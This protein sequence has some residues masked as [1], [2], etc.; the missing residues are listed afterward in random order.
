MS[1]SDNKTDNITQPTGNPPVW[2]VV[3]VNL[4]LLLV[5]TSILLPLFHLAIGYVKWLLATGAL[6]HLAG[7]VGAFGCYRSLPVRIRRLHRMEL[8]AALFF[9]VAAVFMFIKVGRVTDCIAFI[10]AG[11]ATLLYTSLMIPRAQRDRK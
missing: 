9:V 11:G 2:S 8:W 1:K 4:G 10:L 5:M 6:L 3:A 7:R